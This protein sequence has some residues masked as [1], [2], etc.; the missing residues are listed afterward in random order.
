MLDGGVGGSAFLVLV[1]TAQ[2]K[3]AHI[4]EGVVGSE[5]FVGADAAALRVQDV[6]RQRLL[7]RLFREALAAQR[8]VHVRAPDHFLRRA[9]ACPEREVRVCGTYLADCR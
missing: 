1:P 7:L 6:L 8:H 3:L 9:G 4:Y 2:V 5:A